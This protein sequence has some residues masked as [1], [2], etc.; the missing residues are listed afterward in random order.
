MKRPIY[1]TTRKGIS[2]IYY[3]GKK[4]GKKIITAQ[5][6]DEHGMAID[7]CSAS[8]T[9]RP[10]DDDDNARIAARNKALKKF[11]ARFREN[12]TEGSGD[13]TD[14]FRSRWLDISEDKRLD[15]APEG[16]GAKS[17]RA[18][19]IKYFENNV[20]PLLD[21]YGPLI[22]ADECRTV[23]EALYAKTLM[24]K[25]YTHCFVDK[26]ATPAITSLL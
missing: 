10:Y 25:N 19:T 17:S 14:F 21:M 11:D 26:G 13:T 4:N 16:K 2:V 22:T 24:S 18:S 7:G 5:L 6:V 3:E 15:L 1:K 20:L 23:S 12:F 9:L 8:H